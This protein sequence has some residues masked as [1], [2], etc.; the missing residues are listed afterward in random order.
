MRQQKDV[1]IIFGGGLD[2]VTPPQQVDP[3][4]LLEIKNYE[5]D[6]NGGYRQTAGFERFDGSSSPV[7]S[8][9]FAIGTE[10]PSGVMT[11]GET[12]TQAVSGATGILLEI[13]TTGIY[14]VNI[15]GTF[16][17][18]KDIVTQLPNIICSDYPTLKNILL[19]TDAWLI[20]PPIELAESLE[21]GD[22]IQLDIQEPNL[23]TEL[24]VME[25]VGRT[26]SPAA[27]AFIQI[28]QDYFDA[29]IV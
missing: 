26:R 28:C 11:I 27:A 21:S 17:D 25:Q 4:K 20:A 22:I 2:L 13:G 1:T 3:G 16:D 5:C 24:S 9:W 29:K 8:D 6:L 12:V 19:E 15:T 18:M 7:D 14:L 10:T 23:H